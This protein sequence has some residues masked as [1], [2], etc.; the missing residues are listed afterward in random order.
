MPPKGSPLSEEEVKLFED[1]IAAGAECRGWWTEG[2]PHPVEGFVKRFP[3]IPRVAGR[4]FTRLRDAG[5]QVDVGL[6]S[7]EA[8]EVNAGFLSRIERQRPHVLLKLAT[9]LDGRI[10]TRTGESRWI[11]GSAARRQVHL[12][13]A[14]SDAILIG[15]GTARADDPML[16]VR[17]PGL[18]ARSPERVVLDGG[19]SISLTSRLVRTAKDVPTW[20]LHRAV[21][22]R[23]PS[24]ASTPW[25][26]NRARPWAPFWV[27]ICK[28]WSR[29]RVVR[30][31]SWISWKKAQ[32][33]RSRPGSAGL[34]M[35]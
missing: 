7:A 17:L 2:D 10:A 23:S 1:W 13:R 3:D 19:L 4:G 31:T 16:D 22:V 30:F 5:I 24:S 28:K 33:T 26:R 14:Q 8:R 25:A 12:M 9:T 6:M 29:S 27:S 35:W 34:R 15:A 32:T 11:T 18:G 20:V 21:G